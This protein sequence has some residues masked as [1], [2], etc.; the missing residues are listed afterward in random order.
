MNERERGA[1]IWMQLTK[2]SFSNVLVC[3][4]PS[5]SCRPYR[6]Y[7]FGFSR[8]P[9]LSSLRPLPRLK[10][11]TFP[12]DSNKSH[13]MI[14]GRICLVLAMDQTIWPLSSLKLLTSSFACSINEFQFCY[15]S[16]LW[17]FSRASHSYSTTRTKPKL[18]RW[19]PK[20]F[21]EIWSPS[22]CRRIEWF[23]Q[24]QLNWAYY[25]PI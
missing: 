15:F 2:S 18:F 12:N 21:A 7:P 5:Y 25:S 4:F 13:F 23:T 10:T 8:S 3:L 24:W 20:C 1:S 11:T 17:V 6:M 9:S 22:I 16:L 19:I 14:I